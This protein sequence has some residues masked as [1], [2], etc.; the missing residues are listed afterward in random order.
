MDGKVEPSSH[1][2][3][4]VRVPG[5]SPAYLMS[6]SSRIDMFSDSSWHAKPMFT[7]VSANPARLQA[8]L[9]SARSW[10][11]TLLPKAPPTTES[12]S[13]P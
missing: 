1:P 11:P 9:V 7:A 6:L 5:R 3:D 12:W 2:W 10:S 4:G 8:L 13:V